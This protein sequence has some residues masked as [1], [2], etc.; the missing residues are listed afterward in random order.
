MV[1]PSMACG[2]VPG[3]QPAH[4]RAPQAAFRRRESTAMCGALIPG[5]H[6]V[7]ASGSGLL[8]ASTLPLAVINVYQDQ[9]VQI[10]PGRYDWLRPWL[11]P[12]ARL[13]RGGCCRSQL[14]AIGGDAP[15]CGLRPGPDPWR[16]GA[17]RPGRG[18]VR[19]A[20]PLRLAMPDQDEA[21]HL[22]AGRHYARHIPPFLP[23]PLRCA[24][25]GYTSP[26]AR[27]APVRRS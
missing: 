15:S 8:L 19:H 27:C 4:E 10:L 26:R 7:P 5:V 13:G 20:V 2:P 6:S 21:G 9:G 1:W 3:Q 24:A 12:S 16:S 14:D 23:A 22:I 17:R 25:A 18:S 11:R